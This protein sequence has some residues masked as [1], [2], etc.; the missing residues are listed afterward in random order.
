MLKVMALIFLGDMRVLMRS[1]V[2]V[3]QRYV[4]LSS[5]AAARNFPHLLKAMQRTVA[6][7]SVLVVVA[8]VMVES[9]NNI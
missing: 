8:E 9:P 7:C 6:G 2:S 4:V 3:L 1:Q 5:V